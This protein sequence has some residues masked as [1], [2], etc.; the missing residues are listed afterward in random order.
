MRMCGCVIAV[1]CG[2]LATA[3][4]GSA[5]HPSG[6][7][8]PGSTAAGTQP[9]TQPPATNSVPP[10]PTESGPPIAL[11]TAETENEML[12]V[13]LPAGRVIARVHVAPG[14]QTL[15]AGS[16]GPV[17]VVS[18]ASGTVTLVSR[19]TLHTVAVLRGFRSPQIAAVAPDGR[20]ALVSDAA[21]GSLS[22]VDLGSGRVVDRVYVGGGAH[23]MAISPDS[24]TV[25]VALGETA[26]AIV[27]VNCRD[28]RHPRV[29]RRLHPAVD[30][31]DLAF[32][33]DGTTV[34]VSSAAAPF[35]SVLAA[36]SGRLIGKVAAGAPPQHV[37]F[38]PS[39]T[40]QAVITSGYGSTIEIV[41]A[42]TRR[43]LRTAATPYG[44]FNVAAGYNMIVTTSLLNGE[45]TEFR[46]ASLSRR[47]TTTV[48]P[49]AR[50]IALVVR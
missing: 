47:R 9:A 8:A 49:A 38:I 46:A 10:A 43:V 25:W 15:A 35:V 18:P 22:T 16:S 14:P 28:P 36:D 7:Q 44:S 23:H 45:V 24:G 12:A 40:P 32:S 27:I 17:V 19:R 39:R 48:A 26:K 21:A 34:W 3:C 13:S 2:M 41:D 4:A 20:W 50:E 11:V 42:A 33:P 30:A 1:T 31:H 5:S 6:S 37:V 29:E